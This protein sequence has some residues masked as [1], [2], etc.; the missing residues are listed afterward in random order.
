MFGSFAGKQSAADVEQ[1]TALEAEPWIQA[2]DLI[3]LRTMVN[4]TTSKA[5]GRRDSLEQGR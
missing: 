1:L 5:M 4:R 2:A 3:M